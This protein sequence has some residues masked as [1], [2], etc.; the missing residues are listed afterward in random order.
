MPEWSYGGRATQTSATRELTAF[1][2]ANHVNGGQFEGWDDVFNR[3]VVV[4]N[5][6]NVGQSD[7]NAVYRSGEMLLHPAPSG[8]TVIRWTCPSAGTYAVSAFWQD[9]SWGG[10]DGCN[11]S[12]IRNGDNVLFSADFDNVHGTSMAQVAALAQG[13]IIEFVL[14]SRGG[15]FADA[16][17]FD[18]VVKRVPD[19]AAVW[20]AGR[21]LIGK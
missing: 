17:R 5:A 11:A 13:D 4:V 20:V 10:G 16:T 6:S 18:A 19:A 2:S 12:V 14:G 15:Y 8:F 7:A 3:G 21:D 9:G 1:T